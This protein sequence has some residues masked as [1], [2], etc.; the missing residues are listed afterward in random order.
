MNLGDSTIH[1]RAVVSHGKDARPVVY[2][3]HPGKR[4]CVVCGVRLL[5]KSSCKYLCA[6]F[7]MNRSHRFSGINTQESNCWVI[8]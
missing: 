4:I 1:T 6:R 7:C 8:W 3:F 5:Q 2:P